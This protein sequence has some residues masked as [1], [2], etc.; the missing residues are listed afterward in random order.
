MFNKLLQRQLTKF[1]GSLNDIPEEQLALLKII[2]ESY[3]HSERD[4]SMLERSIEISSKEMVE[5]NDKLRKETIELKK[6]HSELK[7]LFDNIDDVF[8]T[9][10]MTNYKLLQMSSN[11]EKMYGYPIECFYETPNLWFDVVI[12]KDKHIIQNNYP[13]MHAGQ[14]FTQQYRISR[15]DGN[16]RY[17]ETKITPTLNENGQLIRIDGIST[18]ITERKRAEKKA[19]QS[20]T[21][22]RKLVENSHDG[23]ALLGSHRKL[24]YVSPSVFRILGYTS[25]ELME[26]DL[27]DYI[28]PND[29]ERVTKALEDIITR[30]GETENIIYQVKSKNGVWRWLNSSITN[31]LHE[32]SIKAIVFNYGDITERINAELQIEYDRRNS[33]ALINS[34]NDLM[35]SI[36][37]KGKLIKAN[38]AFISLMELIS[39]VSFKSG[40]VLDSIPGISAENKKRWEHYYFKAFSGESQVFEECN[41][42][43][44]QE[45]WNEISMQ[46]IFEN[47]EVTGVSCFSRNIS[48]S[49]KSLEIIKR[50]EEMMAEAQ[51]I[52]HFGSWEMSLIESENNSL[53][54]LKWSDELYRIFGRK[55]SEYESNIKNF[56][57]VVH[58]DDRDI[59]TG[60]ME[61]ALKE[62]SKY[63]IEHRVVLPNGEIRWVVENA[64][65]TVNEKTMMPQKMIGTVEDITYRKKAELAQK[66]AEANLRNILENTDTAYVLLDLDATVLSFN[67]LAKD[68]SVTHSGKAI[69]EGVNYIDIMLDNRKLEVR[70]MI[71][72]VITL[73]NKISYETKYVDN[74]KK[75]QWLFVSITPILND[76]KELFG[77][78]VAARNITNRKI[79]E[80]ERAKITTEL[81]QRNKDLEQF[82]Y[83]VSHNLRSP[84]ASILGLANVLTSQGMTEE[85]RNECIKGFVTS[86]K[87]L[88]NTIIDL[89]YILQARKEISEKK[90]LVEFS[91][92]VRSIKESIGNLITKEEV[93]IDVDFSSIN[94]M[95]TLKSYIYSIFYNLI[96]NSIKYRKLTETPIIKITSKQVDGKLIIVFSDNCIGIDME[97]HGDKVFGLYKRF[98]LNVEG[99]GM[100]L[101]MVKTQVET[102]GGKVSLTSKVNVGTEIT[103]EFNS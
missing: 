5:L 29:K 79:F 99:K 97:E 10:D 63:N 71:D 52:A 75:E 66:K 89:N 44:E 41:N 68:L 96:S 36:D 45:I 18:D 32:S 101:Y 70:T 87:N 35:W 94:E 38:K 19:H 91:T 56:F 15:K 51:R 76:D 2:S 86:V 33:E 59:V 6:T 4:R 26:A 49:K 98:H 55:R 90:E 95:Y 24:I 83:I 57:A 81:T 58:P 47:N 88:D 22:F 64:N 25:D 48:E 46:P 50:S 13:T 21:R 84:V 7:T 1:Y 72:S 34:T 37:T 82:T 100:G 3:D 77:L 67:H 40:D 85:V 9:V 62:N 23:I 80:L 42:F 27:M 69:K 12:E 43:N 39:G 54:T 102:L 92:I 11:C 8:F 28:H 30:Y 16:L 31:M 78:S 61:K 14:R 65:I 93:K 74:H 73:K 103:L 60:A 17:L 20:E 53:N